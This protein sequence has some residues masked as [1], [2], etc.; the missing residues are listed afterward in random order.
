MDSEFLQTVFL[1]FKLATVTTVI[2]FLIGLPLSYFLA[3]KDFRF[4]PVVETVVSLPLVLPPTVL[5]FYL[6]VLLSPD[7][8]I[9]RFLQNIIGKQL[10]FSFEGI[11]IGSVIY[12]LPFLVHPF[13]SGFQSVPRSIIEASYTLGK[14]KIETLIKVILPNMK[15]SILTGI[16]L[17]FAHTVGEFGVVLMIGGSIPGETKVASIAIYEEVEALNYSKANLYAVV[18]FIITFLILITVYTVNRRFTRA[19]SL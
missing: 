1:T 14:G 3:Y 10:I 16:V 12:S 5:G 2:L 18:L 7:S 17:A 9:G 11:V 15:H 13:Q 19:D 8:F 6:L 4:K